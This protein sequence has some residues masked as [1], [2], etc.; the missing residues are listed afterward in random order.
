MKRD[1]NKGLPMHNPYDQLPNA[2]LFNVTSTDV[3]DGEQKPLAHVSS[4]AGGQDISPHL[5][6]SG[7]PAETKSFVVTMYDPDAPTASG[8][9]HWAVADIP[10]NVTELNQGAGSANGVL[11]EGAFHLK[12][13]AGMAGY[14]GAAPPEGHGKHRYF[15]VVHALD[16]DKI[17]LDDQATPAYL[18]FAMFG[19]TIGRAILTTWYES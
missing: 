5:H 4:M 12:N 11:P 14:L 19:H 7:F 1:V 3:Q 17:G 16:V 13:D 15:I 18:G 6:W 8:F 10:A 9:W 2:Q